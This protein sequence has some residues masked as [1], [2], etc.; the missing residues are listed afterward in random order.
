MSEEM[1]QAEVIAAS[2]TIAQ[3]AALH[4]CDDRWRNAKEIGA[5]GP[6]LTSLC[7]FWPKGA[8]PISPCACLLSRDYEDAPLRY[9]YRLTDT[10]KRVRSLLPPPPSEV[11]P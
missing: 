10:G 11:T 5:R 6:T 3:V 1:N 4:S 7:W 8:D 9:I 2:L